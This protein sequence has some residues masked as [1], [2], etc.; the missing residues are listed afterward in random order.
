MALHGPSAQ[1][2][3]AQAADAQALFAGIANEAV[4]VLGFAYLGDDYRLVGLRHSHS[5]WHDRHR[6]PIQEVARDALVF[7]AAAVVMAH[8]HPSGDATPSQA[9]KDATRLLNRALDTI[10]VRLLD[11]LVLAR[12]GRAASFRALGLL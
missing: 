4:E 12:G 11:H 2:R 6:I 9:D 5:P 7:R 10:E 1:F 8:N 3:L